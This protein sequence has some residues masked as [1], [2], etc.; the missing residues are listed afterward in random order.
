[1]W[2]WARRPPPRLDPALCRHV[3]VSCSLTA[4]RLGGPSPTLV[5]RSGCLPSAWPAGVYGGG[6]LLGLGG[7]RCRVWSLGSSVPWFRL[8]LAV[9]RSSRVFVWPAVVP[10]PGPAVVPYPVW[11]LPDGYLYSASS[12]LRSMPLLPCFRHFCYPVTA[13]RQKGR[14]RR[15]QRR[16]RAPQATRPG[17]DAPSDGA[18]EE[19]VADRLGNASGA[20]GRVVAAVVVLPPPE[21]CREPRRHRQA[22]VQHLPHEVAPAT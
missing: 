19:D 5:H 10:L 21:L 3:R 20:A 17:R 9:L 7:R 2:R 11:L 16:R 22:A 14:R 4:C 12:V 8:S 18:V 6:W 1:M 13:H 15:R